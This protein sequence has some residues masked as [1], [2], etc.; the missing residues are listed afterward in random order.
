M[1]RL[2]TL[3]GVSKLLL[4]LPLGLSVLLAAP[5][6]RC[7]ECELIPCGLFEAVLRPLGGRLGASLGP[8]GGLLGLLGGLLG[9]LGGLVGR[10]ARIF[11]SYFPSWAP[12][13]AVLG[14]CWAVLGASWAVLRPSW[15]VLGLSWGPLGASWGHLGG[16]LGDLGAI[17]GA[18]WAVLG[19]RRAEK[20]I[21]P[22]SFKNSR[23]IKDFDPFGP[24]W[25]T[26]WRAHGPSWRPLAVR[27]GRFRQS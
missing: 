21:M 17:L 26:S 6:F 25:R 2:E 10:K 19:R 15:A 1:V 27:L 11:G 24:S 16:L 14:L 20:T 4:T 9:P 7:F 22:K 5:R 12:S 23:K 3:S 13:G 18:A 8:L